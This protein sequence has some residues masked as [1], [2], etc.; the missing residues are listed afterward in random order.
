[1]ATKR[2]LS[3]EQ[4]IAVMKQLEAGRSA[5]EMAREVGVSTYTIY[6]WKAKYGGMA[7][8]EAMKLRHLEDENNRLKKLVAEVCLDR[9]MLKALV[10]KNGLSS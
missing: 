5:A 9:E 3:D 1:M 10:I 2:K 6:S 8:T 4:I 7:P